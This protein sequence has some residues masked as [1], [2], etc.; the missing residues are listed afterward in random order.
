V[1]HQGQIVDA[2]ATARRQPFQPPNVVGDAPFREHVKRGTE[3]AS[4]ASQ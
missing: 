2:L 4:A 3:T 1:L